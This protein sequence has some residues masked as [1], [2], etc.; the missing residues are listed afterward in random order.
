MCPEINLRQLWGINEL[1]VMSG[2]NIL[3]SS[4][5]YKLVD[6]NGKKF[7]TV[8]FYDKILDLMGRDGCTLVGSRFSQILGSKMEL[9]RISESAR[10]A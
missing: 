6:G 3:P 4:F 5:Q 10:A 8:K 1:K 7:V 2:D 9:S